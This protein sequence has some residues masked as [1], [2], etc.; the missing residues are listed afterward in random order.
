MTLRDELA[1]AK[2][3]PRAANCTQRPPIADER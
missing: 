1:T 2:L 3:L